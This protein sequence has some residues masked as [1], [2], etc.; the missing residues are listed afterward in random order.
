MQDTEI[1][2]KENVKNLG[3]CG[4]IVR[5][6]PGYARNYLVPRG[7]GIAATEDNKKAMARRR[8]V[9]DVEEAKMFA[10]IDGQLGAM[11]GLVFETVERTDANGHLYGS[12]SAGTIAGLLVAAG[13]KVEE[14]NVRLEKPIK[15][16]GTYEVSIHLHAERSTVVTVEVR[17]EGEVL[18][19][20]E[21]VSEDI[22]DEPSE[23]ELTEG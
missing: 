1:L 19:P 21:V 12:V 7:I 18:A 8:E 14:K 9:L 11:S 15:V 17:P 3:R 20:A 4:D 16:V 2:L 10:V 5:V 13:H 6:A 23:E 22:P